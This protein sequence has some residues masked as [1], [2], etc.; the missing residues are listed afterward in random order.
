MTE[1]GRI[2]VVGLGPGA[3]ALLTLGAL[4]AL[5]A[6]PSVVLRTEQHPVVA[7]LGELGVQYTSYDHLYEQA[8]TFAEVYAAI[9]RDLVCRAAGGPVVYAVPGHP[10]VGEQTVALLQQEAAQHK[11][12]LAVVSGPSF[13]DTVFTAVGC[14]PLGGLEVLDALDLNRR[15]PAGDLPAVIAQLYSRAVAA[16]VKL[17]LMEV[18]PDDHAVTVVQAAGV[19]GRERIATMPLYELD[20]HDWLDYLCTLYVPPLHAAANRNVPLDPLVEVMARLRGPDGC[21]WDREQTHRSLRPYLLEESYE[22]LEAIDQDDADLL[23]EELGDVLLQ[24][25]FHA[26]LAAEEGRF[27]IGDVVQKITAKLI[28]RHPHV[29]GTASAGTTAEVLRTWQAVKAAEKGGATDPPLLD[30]VTRGLPALLYALEIQRRAAKMGFDWQDIHGPLQKVREELSEFAEAYVERRQEKLEA[31]L[32]DLLFAVVN[33]ARLADLNPEVALSAA[34]AKFRRRV[35]AVKAQSERAGRL[36]T[37]M[38][39]A[40]LDNL[41]EAVKREENEGGSH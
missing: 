20:H 32:G 9:V 2:T 24:V 25:V 35:A 11:I 28:R 4:E 19:A 33:V 10:L 14:D 40:E 39:P 1:P 21:P 3:T 13:L 38:T 29:F 37:D 34:S 22:L 41:W 36:L 7:A 26:Q 17:T 5:R 16:D 27:S 6:A 18:Y 23:A 12:E 31:E 8:D 15:R 30:A